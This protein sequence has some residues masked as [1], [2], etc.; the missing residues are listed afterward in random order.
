LSEPTPKLAD[1]L[2]KHGTM[3]ARIARGFEADPSA[4]QDLLQD[5]SLALWRALPGFQQRGSLA[6]YVAGIAHHVSV[7]HVAR[8]CKRQSFTALDDALVDPMPAPEQT[9]A[10]QQSSAQLVAAIQKLPLAYA[11]VLILQLEGFA[12]T[13]IAE[14]L[15]V[16]ANLV[17]VRANRARE[18][19]KHIMCAPSHVVRIKQS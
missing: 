12:Q 17:G 14:I 5:I 3:L 13:E 16:S 6:A 11:E 1:V 10:Q 18:Q 19:L 15:G 9:L 2:Q 8:V 7:E 4:R